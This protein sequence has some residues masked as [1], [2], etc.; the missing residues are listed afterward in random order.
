M[1]LDTK[2]L[3]L[4]SISIGSIYFFLA[5][6]ALCTVLYRPVRRRPVDGVAA[7]SYPAFI[8]SVVYIVSPAVLLC[9]VAIGVC[10]GV[11]NT[12][13]GVVV[14]RNSTEE[15]RGRRSGIFNAFQ[16][17]AGLPGNLVS[18]LFIT[19]TPAP[20]SGK[21]A[22]DRLLLV[23][24]TAGQS[25]YFLAMAAF[26]GCGILFLLLIEEEASDE[27]RQAAVV[28]TRPPHRVAEQGAALVVSSRYLGFSLCFYTGLS[29]PSGGVCSPGD[30]RHKG[31]AG[32]GRPN[33]HPNP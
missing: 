17:S 12:A 21:C 16:Q 25:P 32:D 10:G 23:G 4:G 13:N 19:S 2:C 33:P 24:W 22:L 15:N 20:F 7:V 14:N 27:A 11:L 8:G 18:L 6:S 28:E 29:Q 30:R 5:I 26:C 1:L 3:P 9:S 31:G